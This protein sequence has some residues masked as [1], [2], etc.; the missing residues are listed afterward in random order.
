[1]LLHYV[2]GNLRY[3]SDARGNRVPY[4]EMQAAISYD[5]NGIG[6]GDGTVKQ[7][8]RGS[9]YFTQAT[10][11]EAKDKRP[12]PSDK[13]QYDEFD[14]DTNGVL[15]SKR[16]DK[17]TSSNPEYEYFKLYDPVKFSFVDR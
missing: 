14:L 3:Y 9:Y 8:V 2:V 13:F 5:S 6:E 16:H 1:M 17:P 12:R 7:R 4:Y 10:N 15:L 11:K